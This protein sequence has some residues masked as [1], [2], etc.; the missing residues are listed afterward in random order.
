MGFVLFVLKLPLPH[1][2]NFAKEVGTAALM[3][4]NRLDLGVGMSWMPQ[5]Y[6]YC[7]LD[8]GTRRQRFIESIEVLRLVLTGDMGEPHGEAFD[9]A[10]VIAP[11][12]PTEPVPILIGGHNE[13]SLKL[14]AKIADGWC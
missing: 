8:W 6:E 2:L 7:G 1:P 12:A 3:M 11:P 4:H 13:A 9:F 5:E 14:A 10:P